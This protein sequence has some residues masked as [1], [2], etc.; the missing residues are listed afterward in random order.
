MLYTNSIKEA[1][2]EF[3]AKLAIPK[4]STVRVQ[5][6]ELRLRGLG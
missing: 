1:L 4:L 2:K 5:G 3:Y 6:S